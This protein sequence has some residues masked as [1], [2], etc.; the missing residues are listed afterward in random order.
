MDAIPSLDAYELSDRYDRA[1]GR[2]FLTGTQAIVR[3]A[4]DQARRDRASGL[5]TAGFISG[6]RGS[7]L[8]GIDLELWRIK[9]QL[10]R[11]RIEF[12][13]AVNEDL[14]ATAV[15]G[16]QQVETQADREVDGVFG[17]WY[18]KGPGVDRSGDA[19]KHGNAYGSSPHG[20]VLVVAG[21][22]HGCVSSSMPH[23]SDV[24]F[25]SWF[26][27]TLHPASISEYLEFGEYGYAL[28]RFSG[29]WVGFKAI[30]EIVESGASVALRPSRLFRRPDF[31]PPPGGLH[32]RWPDLPGPQIEERLEAK[33]HAVYAFAKANPID[34]HIYDIPNATYGIVT[35]G[36]AHLDL[37]EALRLIGLD[38]TACRS[39][40]IDVYKVGMV[41][42][43]AL[44]DA[45]EFVKGKREI[46]V[47]EEKRGI[48]ES[49]F[50]EYFY[51][52]P[53]AKPERMV[54]K[55]DETGARLI[56]WIGELSPRALAGVLARR[57]DPMFPGLNLAVRA[58]ALVPEPERTIS[59]T[60]ATRTPYFCSGCPHN[61]S[62]KVPEGSKALAGIGC[63]FMASWM[64]RETSSLI[65]M[66]GEGVNWAASSRFTGDK[67]VFQN[68]GEGTYYHS[69]SMAI[70]QA[71]AAGANITYKILFNDAVAMTG[72]QPVDGPVSVQAIAHSVRAEGVSRIAL[73]SD[74]PSQFSLADLPIDVTIHPRE[75][76]DA[77][78]RELRDVPGVSVLI[79]QQTCAT[80]KR[81]QRKRGQ[82]ADP[83]R[84]AYI[85]DLVCEGCGDC[86]VESNCLS[87]EPKE[88]PLGRKRRINLSACNKDFSCLNGFC[89]SF[90]TVEGATRRA[91]TASNIDAIGRAA[92]LAPPTPAMLERPY[93]LLVT[94]VGGTGV[95]TV[96]ALIGMAAH[97]ERRGVSVLDFTGFAQKFGPVL[98]YIRLAASPQ[99]LHQVRIDQG[100]ADALI[101][102]DLVVSSS[103]KAS[104]T[105]RHGTRAAI[106]TAE[107]PTGDVVRFR[108][109][110][111]AS[112]AR[113]RAIGRV[114]G[115]GNLDTINANA[116]AESQLGDAVYANIIML[117]F[118][119]QRG[120][121]PLS[122]QALL[123]AIELN[124]VA[125]ERNKQAFAWGRIA[126]ADPEFLTKPEDDPVAETL[127][128]VIDRRAEFLTGYQH[129]AYAA[130]YR[131]AIAK[132]R[133]AES[134]LG[135]EAL[136][137]AVARSLF[138]L[139]AYKDEYE[140]ARL[141]MQT[142]FLDTLNREF[143]GDFKIKYHL[144]P[145]FLA[146]KRDARGR[147][148]KRAFGQWIQT[149]LAILARLKLLRGTPFDPFGYTAERR[150]E[151]ELIGWYEGLIETML[152]RL[153]ATSLSDMVVIAR[154]PME[155]RGYGPVKDAAIAKV[156]AEVAS[157]LDRPAAAKAA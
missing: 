26:M 151:R 88:T 105:Y 47:V 46:L 79:Y 123:R 8:G 65:Q 154:A 19:L 97:L 87:V 75:E 55:H 11:D 66:G 35:T 152:A 140:V 62:T 50:K 31:T 74:E 54:G 73:A 59:V 106:N 43:L 2:V 91:R 117:G 113:L 40:G 13:P 63:H 107:M 45:M 72:G 93:D 7:P 70:R 98:S 36:K 126:A 82:M 6:Y 110:D 86:S 149:P 133:R 23:Q 100:A 27:P 121:V 90:V 101:G 51:D 141:H 3:V 132:V 56:S 155:I 78:Q 24:A 150:A 102:C 115:E 48:I 118:A 85:N 137:D 136:T 124:G 61:T 138:K 104:G 156:K 146:S 16:S 28:S 125:V 120:L 5:N 58:A 80:E 15:L 71:I 18:G 1:E 103:P 134:R 49:Q 122:L 111:L 130:H 116:L 25:M 108:D 69:G 68:L 142:G 128:Q 95:I 96:G 112:P 53:G 109:A 129:A 37:M 9:E 76:M 20:G 139:M 52:Y 39:I 127:D 144:A 38:E 153:D 14:A 64:D 42:P 89:P 135:S 114:I 119:W 99:A 22:D 77:V 12:L 157:L 84:F 33:K 143:D 81:R 41:W 44:H 60:G 83:K 148:R 10:K 131:G 21:D 30:S 92:T 4:L 29:M 34:R 32:Y 145:P 94:G 147:P 17:L 57:L 67:H